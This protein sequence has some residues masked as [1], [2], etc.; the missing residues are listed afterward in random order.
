MLPTGQQLSTV[1]SV[2]TAFEIMKND[3]RD[4]L[5]NYGIFSPAGSSKSVFGKSTIVQGNVIPNIGD[6]YLK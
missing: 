5:P 1:R 3:M 2:A 4:E 6:T